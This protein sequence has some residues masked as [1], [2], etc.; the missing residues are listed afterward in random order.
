[1][2]CFIC[3]GNVTKTP[4]RKTTNNGMV[5]SEFGLAVPR[6]FRREGM[7]DADFFD[8]QAFGKTAEF[9]LKYFEKGKPIF[10]RGRFENYDYTNR[11]GVKIHRN[12]LIVD[13]CDFGSNKGSGNNT[14]KESKAEEANFPKPS[15]LFMDVPDGAENEMP[16]V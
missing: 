9:I 2:N 14:A 13:E 12:R 5:V 15:S 6:R 16:F 10:V 4:E 3:K 11:E 8:C 7:P 1:M